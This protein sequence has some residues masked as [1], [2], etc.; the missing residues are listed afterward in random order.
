MALMIKIQ[1]IL[2]EVTVS[3]SQFSNVAY[4]S[5]FYTFDA[6]KSSGNKRRSPFI[7][8][9]VP[10]LTVIINGCG[11]GA[12]GSDEIG[13]IGA[14]L[15]TTEKWTSHEVNREELKIRWANK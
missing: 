10:G 1:K 12:K 7:D 6:R 13:R 8:T 2:Y 15:A 3:C 5:L 9:L 4:K 11:L 14:K